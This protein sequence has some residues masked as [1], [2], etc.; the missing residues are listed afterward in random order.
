MIALILGLLGGERA[1]AQQV[2]ID[3]LGD[4]SF[5]LLSSTAID[6]KQSRNVC[7]SSTGSGRYTIRATGSGSGGL[8]TLAGAGAPMVY[9]VQWSASAGQQNGTALVPGRTL[10]GLTTTALGLNLGCLLSNSASLIIVLRAAELSTATAGAYSGT[11][12]LLIAPE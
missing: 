10:T 5:G 7:I 8:F 6:V 11:L 1:E 12:T 2:R 4:Y 3:Q 9:D